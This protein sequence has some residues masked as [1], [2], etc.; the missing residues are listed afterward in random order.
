MRNPHEATA[1]LEIASRTPLENLLPTFAKW[2][3]WVAPDGD[4]EDAIDAMGEHLGETEGG[5]RFFQTL[6]I[7]YWRLGDRELSIEYFH[8]CL[9]PAS[10]LSAEIQQTE[11]EYATYDYDHISI[12][13]DTVAAFMEFAPEW[14]AQCSGGTLIDAACGSGLAAP[15]LKPYAGTLIGIDISSTMATRAQASGLYDQVIEAD[16]VTTLT[17]KPASA[18]IIVCMGAAYYLADLAPFMTACATALRPG[19]LLLFSDYSAPDHMGTG[20]TFG[21]TRRYCR[22]KAHL[23]ALAAHAG[24]SEAGLGSGIAF[25]SPSLYWAFRRTG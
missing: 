6:A 13:R 20:I 7:L 18:D 2:S 14:L 9:R 15:A 11:A 3:A 24:L 12:H 5:Y 8:R 25:A 21:G 19:G 22:S 10:G 23:R 4:L 16:M 17:A 1:A